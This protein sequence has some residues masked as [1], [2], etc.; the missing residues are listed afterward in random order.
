MLSF[1]GRSTDL[2]LNSRLVAGRQ[3][4]VP[5]VH[6]RCGRLRSLTGI[7]KCLNAKQWSKPPAW[8]TFLSVFNRATGRRDIPFATALRRQVGGCAVPEPLSQRN[9]MLTVLL[10]QASLPGF[11]KLRSLKGCRMDSV[12]GI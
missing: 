4:A 1:I 2:C 8:G 12:D 6:Q 10:L 11:A 7:S 9:E 5:G 3:S